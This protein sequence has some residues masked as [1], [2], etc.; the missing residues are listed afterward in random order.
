ML[1]GE[2]YYSNELLFKMKIIQAS[3]IP[4]RLNGVS[5]DATCS[6]ETYKFEIPR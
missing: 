1:I 3:Q 6:K 4:V 2:C 5:T